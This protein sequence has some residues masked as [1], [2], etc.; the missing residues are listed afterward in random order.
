MATVKLEKIRK[1]YPNA[2]VVKQPKKKKK[3]EEVHEEKKANL[4]VTEE[5]VIA[6]DD[7]KHQF[8]E[9]NS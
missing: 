3:E 1:I 9:F 2:E 5:G 8:H 6:V 7:F 4:K